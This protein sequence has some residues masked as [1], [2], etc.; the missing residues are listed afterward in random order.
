MTIASF[1][2]LV[3]LWIVP[4]EKQHFVIGLLSSVAFSSMNL[5][6]AERCEYYLAEGSAELCHSWNHVMPSDSLTLCV[7]LPS[8]KTPSILVPPWSLRLSPDVLLSFAGRLLTT[9]FRAGDLSPS[10]SRRTKV[11]VPMRNTSS[12]DDPRS[13]THNSHAGHERRRRG[14][15]EWGTQ[16]RMGYRSSKGGRP[17]EP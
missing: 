9:F 3:Y 17:R 13:P 10:K 1:A 14:A 7:P 8:R 15:G 12:S 6:I 16:R 11:F 4:L 2:T 5:R